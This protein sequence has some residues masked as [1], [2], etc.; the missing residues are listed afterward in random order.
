LSKA[1]RLPTQRF[2]GL[3]PFVLEVFDAV[4][5]EQHSFCGS[6]VTSSG[7]VEDEA[8]AFDWSIW[9]ERRSWPSGPLIGIA[10]CFFFGVQDAPK[11]Y[12]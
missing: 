7:T 5:L 3:E 4:V 6:S 1:V 11:T 2:S 10:G 12:L 8:G 9:L